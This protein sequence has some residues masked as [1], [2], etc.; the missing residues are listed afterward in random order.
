MC[1][2]WRIFYKLMLVKKCFYREIDEGKQEQK[3][4]QIEVKSLQMKNKSLE[5]EIGLL[6]KNLKK[7][8]L[9]LR[10]HKK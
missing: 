6:N 1:S 8:N 10:N 9:E 5:K 7:I 4:L 2:C 3:R